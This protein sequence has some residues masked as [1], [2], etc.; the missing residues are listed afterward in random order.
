MDDT[1][2]GESLIRNVKPDGRSQMA[3]LQMQGKGGENMGHLDFTAKSCPNRRREKV[4]PA[5][6]NYQSK[7]SYGG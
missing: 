1:W 7:A 3:R 6:R 5:A 2:K 4:A